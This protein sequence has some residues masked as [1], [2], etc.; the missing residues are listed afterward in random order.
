MDGLG[1]DPHLN[2]KADAL[3]FHPI[4]VDGPLDPA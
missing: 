2:P 3:E 1:I 4:T